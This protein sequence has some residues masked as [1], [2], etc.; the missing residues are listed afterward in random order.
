MAQS[1]ACK[2]CQIAARELSSYVVFED[3]IS[4]AFLDNRPLF[5]G[6]T[7]LVPKRHVETLAD[8]SS[9]LIAPFFANVQRLARAVEQ[10]LE[11]EGSFVAINNR[12]SQSV[13]HLHVHIVPRKKGDGLRGFFWPRSAHPDEALMKQAQAAIQ[14][15]LGR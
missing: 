14:R 12:V 2:F 10:G 8:L 1:S 11:A 13:P 3:S 5:I 15:A 9:E 7:L 4:L 6:H